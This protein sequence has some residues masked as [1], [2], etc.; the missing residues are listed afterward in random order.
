MLLNYPPQDQ[1]LRKIVLLLGNDIKKESP[2]FQIEKIVLN[3]ERLD[4]QS[5]SYGKIKL[6][7]NGFVLAYSDGNLQYLW[8][9]PL[10]DFSWQYGQ[11]IILKGFDGELTISKKTE[12]LSKLLF[13]L[14]HIRTHKPEEWNY[15]Q[16]N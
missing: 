12:N 4:K 16:L 9:I 11:Q 2:L 1:N 14:F 7:E 3:G 10:E 15:F 6:Y 5:P 13:F 8:L